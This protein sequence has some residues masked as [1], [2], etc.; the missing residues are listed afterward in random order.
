MECLGFVEGNE[1][2]IGYDGVRE[3]SCISRSVNHK[4]DNQ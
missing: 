4:K 2:E 3:S 1:Q